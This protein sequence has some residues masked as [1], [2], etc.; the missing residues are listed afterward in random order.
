MTEQTA[1][2]PAKGRRA[3]FAVVRWTAAVLV[4]ACTGTA[5]AY[6]IT[7]RERTEL[8]G[9]STHS[10]GRWAYPELRK[11]ELPPGAPKPYAEDNPGGIH[12][13]DLGGLLIPA[14]DGATLDEK[15]AGKDGKDGKDGKQ[16]GA[17]NRVPVERFLEAY[18]E[19]DRD[20]LRQRLVDAGLIHVV[21]RGWT[22]PD[23][24]RSRTYLL[25]FHTGGIA[26]QFYRDA[27]A[28]AASAG[29]PVAGVDDLAPLDEEYPEDAIVR[30]TERDVFDEAVPRGE[31]H[32]RHAYITAGDTLALIVQSSRGSTPR[33]PF[34]QTVVLQNQLLG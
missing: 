10:D 17:G 3:L 11:P 31:R 12:Y 15:L 34:H 32:V 29:L 8:P 18:P 23:G 14:P 4:F 9:L 25:R 33:V 5:V 19:D 16:E 21:A 20:E 1:A 28:G 30:S 22:M 24:T 7:E 2:Q 13:A 26:R 27:L 6:G